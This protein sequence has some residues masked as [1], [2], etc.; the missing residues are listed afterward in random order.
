MKEEC[1]ICKAP[2]EYLETDGWRTPL[3]QMGLSRTEELPVAFTSRFAFV[4]PTNYNEK[5]SYH[6]CHLRK[7]P[8]SSH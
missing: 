5:E 2:L 4:F 3:L 8:E 7:N 6:L 1:L